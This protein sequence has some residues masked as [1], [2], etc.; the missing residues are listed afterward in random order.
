MKRILEFKTPLIDIETVNDIMTIIP[1]TSQYFK[2]HKYD[3]IYD[4]KYLVELNIEQLDK[5]CSKYEI[6]LNGMY[7]TIKN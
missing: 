1:E 7:L 2:I 4:Y 5:I 3:Y 6:E